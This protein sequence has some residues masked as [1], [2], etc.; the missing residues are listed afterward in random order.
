MIKN[1][2]KYLPL[3]AALYNPLATAQATPNQDPNKLATAQECT[4]KDNDRCISDLSDYIEEYDGKTRIIGHGQY[5]PKDGKIQP[6]ENADYSWDLTSLY[7]N[8]TSQI[9]SDMKKATLETLG[10]VQKWNNPHKKSLRIAARAAAINQ[11]TGD[12]FDPFDINKD[13][14]ISKADDRNNDNKITAEDLPK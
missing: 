10:K 14:Y 4:T 11:Y 6:S 5:G 9:K 3:V 13:G 1:L 12:H 2:I 7:S 8:F